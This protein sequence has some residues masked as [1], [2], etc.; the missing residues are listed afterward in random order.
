MGVWALDN[1]KVMKA[2]RRVIAH[3]EKQQAARRI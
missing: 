2:A 1:P 3:D